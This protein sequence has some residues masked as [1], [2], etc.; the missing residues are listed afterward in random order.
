MNESLRTKLDSIFTN[1]V[2]ESEGLQT[3]SYANAGASEFDLKKIDLPKALPEV[4]FEFLRYSDGCTLFNCEDLDSFQFFGSHELGKENKEMEKSYEEDWDDSVIIFS[5]IL[6]EGNYIGFKMLDES[7]Y[8]ILDCF[9]EYV[10]EQWEV[11][12]NSFDE[13]LEKL[14]DMKGKKYWLVS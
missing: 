11:I 1:V 3:R 8:Q 13:F 14:I 6:G 7:K 5:T 4:Y 10:P 9:H 12:D 2:T